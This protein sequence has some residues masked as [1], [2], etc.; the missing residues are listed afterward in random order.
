MGGG[1][2]HG[3]AFNPFAN[4]GD[5][6]LIEKI[7]FG[8]PIGENIGSPK[9]IKKNPKEAMLAAAVA[10]TALTGGAAAGAFGGAGAAGAGAAG[11]EGGL[12]GASGGLLSGSAA[13]G[14]PEMGMGAGTAS[15]FG[16]TATSAAALDMVSPMAGAFGS[17]ADLTA[18]G[19]GAEA[20]LDMPGLATPGGSP[21]LLA[22]FQGSAPGMLKKGMKGLQAAKAVGL[23]SP[24]P[25]MAPAR[26][27]APAPAMPNTQIAPPMPPQKPIGMSDED[28]QKFLQQQQQSM[29]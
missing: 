21:G 19:G 9:W 22:Q 20:S 18:A 10:A 7:G 13:T 28:W 1:S 14:L 11:A 16:P 17:A 23:L 2:I 8:L 29:R 27:P 12:A 26:P 15:L 3:S 25:Q 24:Q 6:S 4:W 5:K